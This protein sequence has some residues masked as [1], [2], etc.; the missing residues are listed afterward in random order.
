M[1]DATRNIAIK[2]NGVA[3]ALKWLCSL[4]KQ[5]GGTHP[6][7]GRVRQE[8]R[9]LNIGDISD[10][11]QHFNKYANGKK[12]SR[13]QGGVETSSMTCVFVK[14]D[15]FGCESWNIFAK[16]IRKGNHTIFKKTKFYYSFANRK[17]FEG[18]LAIY[19]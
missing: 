3:V 18:H 7:E 14:H 2:H 5:F 11:K 12:I 19:I 1:K 17:D 4:V 15:A 10:R 13:G 9:M 6:P 16:G 8:I